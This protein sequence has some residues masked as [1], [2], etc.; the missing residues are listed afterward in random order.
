MQYVIKIS[1]TNPAKWS[2][3]APFL[4]TE[5]YGDPVTFETEEAALVMAYLMFGKNRDVTTGVINYEE[6]N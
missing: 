5:E 2:D 1:F 6:A 3:P 4:Y